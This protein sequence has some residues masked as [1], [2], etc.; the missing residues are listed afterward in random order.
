MGYTTDF[1]G[2]FTLNRPLDDETYE[3]LKKFAHTRRMKRRVDSKY[4]IDGE[5]YVDGTGD[6]GQDDDGTVVDHNKPPRTQPSLWCQWIPTEDKLHIEWD[7]GEKFYSYIEW[8]KYIIT[9]FL[10]PKGYSLNG[11]VHWYGEDREDNGIIVVK[12]NKVSTKEGR[13]VYR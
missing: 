1:D 7:G 9:N 3:F 11:K 10:E 8:L 13:I 12:D 2:N 5:F 6:F 4:G